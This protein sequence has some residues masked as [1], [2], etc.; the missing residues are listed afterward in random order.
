MSKSTCLGQRELDRVFRVLQFFIFF[1]IM[2][3]GAIGVG[4]VV[5]MCGWS[6]TPEILLGYLSLSLDVFVAA[7]VVY[8]LMNPNKDNAQFLLALAVNTAVK[9]ER[10]W[11]C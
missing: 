5:Q 9:T 2:M 8:C 1:A 3:G 10:Y 4:C 6:S 11:Q 7:A